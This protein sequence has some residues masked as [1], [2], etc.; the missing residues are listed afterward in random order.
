MVQNAAA[1]VLSGISKR[2]HISPLLASLRWLPVAQRIDFKMLLLTFKALNSRAPLYLKELIIPYR[3]NRAL[4]SQNA[5]LLVVP[6]VSKARLGGKAFSYRAPL[7]WNQL[8]PW[9]READ[10]LSTFKSRPKTFLF[11]K[12]FSIL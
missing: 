5:G 8:S 7:L 10:S 6:T 3:P 9:V 11:D 12:A 4:R 2:E 1:R